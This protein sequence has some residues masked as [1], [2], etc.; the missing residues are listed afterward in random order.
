MAK[1]KKRVA[2]RKKSSKRGKAST[3]P[4]RKMAT[5]H[6]TLKKTKSKVQ[7]ARMSTK[8][9]FAT[10]S[11]V[12]VWPAWLCSA[13]GGRPNKRPNGLPGWSPAAI[14]PSLSMPS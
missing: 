1:A 7:R 6:P 12:L 5:K 10:C 4:A 2:V 3:K 8:A 13:L 14:F 11:S 9:Y